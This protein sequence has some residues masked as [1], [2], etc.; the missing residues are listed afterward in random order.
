MWCKS[1]NMETNNSE[2]PVCGAPTEEDFPIE[3]YWCESCRTPIIQTS[4]QADK[5][6]CPL[7]GNHTKYLA[8]DIRPVFPEERILVEIILGKKPKSRENRPAD[9]EACYREGREARSRGK[10]NQGTRLQGGVR[11]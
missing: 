10:G 9:G 1:C 2:C 6:L 3:I 8:A 4:I 11:L 5:G 7:C